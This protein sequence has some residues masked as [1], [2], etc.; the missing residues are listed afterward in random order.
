[1]N[2]SLIWQHVKSGGLYM[3]MEDEAVNEAD[4]RPMVVYKSLWDGVV[5]C[6]PTEEFHDGR[7]RQIEVD[8]AADCRTADDVILT[9]LGV[10]L[11]RV[12]ELIQEDERRRQT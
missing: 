10:P 7:F 11:E 6:R 4:L 1:M 2:R 3:I 8:E 9:I 5:W 12:V